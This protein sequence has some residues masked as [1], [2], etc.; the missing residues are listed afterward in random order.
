MVYYPTYRLVINYITVRS[1]LNRIKPTTSWTL[2][3]L[4]RGRLFGEHDPSLFV[5]TIDLVAIH[6]STAWRR[7]D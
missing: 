3:L 2:L 6:A 7:I 4:V 5:A 1:I